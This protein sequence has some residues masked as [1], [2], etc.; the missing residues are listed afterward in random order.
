MLHSMQPLMPQESKTVSTVPQFTNQSTPFP[1]NAFVQSPNI[2]E[3]NI[4]LTNA[5]CFIN[6]VL[7]QNIGANIPLVCQV[8]VNNSTSYTTTVFSP[9]Y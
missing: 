2:Q 7:I 6:F 8:V 5:M 9:L 4:H 1:M 3:S